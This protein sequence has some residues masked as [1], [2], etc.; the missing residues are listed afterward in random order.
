MTKIKRNEVIPFVIT[1]TIDKAAGLTLIA[2]T[3][4]PG[5]IT[6]VTGFQITSGGTAWNEAT[7]I[8]IQDDADTPNVFATIV[9][10]GLAGSG[11]LV[12]PWSSSST[13]GAAWSA[14]SA[15]GKAL[16]VAPYGSTET[17]GTNPTITIHGYRVAG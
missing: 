14:G 3:K 2:G 10:A 8:K 16:V 4:Q 6:F 9:K 11:A 1:G 13:C 12:N 17:T 5:F 7:G 15:S